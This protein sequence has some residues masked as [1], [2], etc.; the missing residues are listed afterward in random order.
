MHRDRWSDDRNRK[1]GEGSRERITKSVTDEENSE[2]DSICAGRKEWQS[3][4]RNE[5][6][7]T[8]AT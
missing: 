5:R 4:R 1:V 7:Q 6:I 2:T 3:R 8:E